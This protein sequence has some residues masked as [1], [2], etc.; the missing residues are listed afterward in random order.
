MVEESTLPQS[1][2][3]L[4]ARGIAFDLKE[5]LEHLSKVQECVARVMKLM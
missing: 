2:I 3:K 5:T 4:K 1:K